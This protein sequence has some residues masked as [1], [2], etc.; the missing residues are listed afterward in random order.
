MTSPCEIIQIK[1][2]KCGKVYEDWHR[3]SFNLDL[4]DFDDKYIDEATSSTCPDC[5]HKVRHSALVVRE[6]DGVWEFDLA[7]EDGE[8]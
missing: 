2:P 7:S 6:G 1:C 3:A 4:D 5:K 8:R